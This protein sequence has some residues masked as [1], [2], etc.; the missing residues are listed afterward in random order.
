M[1]T[2]TVF[3]GRRALGILLV[4]AALAGCGGSAPK[5]VASGADNEQVIFT[6]AMDCAASGR[7]SHDQCTKALESAMTAH[8]KK[9]PVYRSLTLCETAEGPEKCERMDEKSY[10]PKLVAVAV[11]PASVKKA[12]E[13]GGMP[14]A[15]PLYPSQAGEKG[16]RTLEKTIYLIDGEMVAFSRQAVAAAELGA[17]TKKK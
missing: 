13:T 17:S 3:F 12:D 1:R 6:S 9:S 5:V 11:T 8:L 16:F 7:I 2:F 10:R 15:T 4:T 14:E